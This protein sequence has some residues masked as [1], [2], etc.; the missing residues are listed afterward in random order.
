[1]LAGIGDRASLRNGRILRMIL[2]VQLKQNAAEAISVAF[3]IMVVHRDALAAGALPEIAD[4]A[5]MYLARD[6]A[7]DASS[8]EDG[9]EFDF[10]IR[11]SRRLPSQNHT[12]A[13]QLVNSSP[14]NIT[15]SMEFR[16]LL[17]T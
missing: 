11:T 16:I 14:S 15:F 5:N 10:D 9:R 8:T 6:F 17:Q 12:L 3:G 13:M 1:M 7:W 4:D 2:H